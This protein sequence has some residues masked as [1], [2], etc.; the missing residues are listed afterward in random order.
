MQAL[1]RLKLPHSLRAKM[2]LWVFV[3]VV[4]IL[5]ILYATIW[6]AA[7]SF[8]TQTRGNISQLLTPFSADIDA[9]LASAKLYVANLRVDLSLLSESAQ[10]SPEG[11]QALS[12]LAENI[13]EDLALYPQIDAFFLY[14]D[15]KMRFV[16]N[17][18]RS[19]PQ[20]RA[21]ALALQDS[22]DSLGTDT[23][24]FQQGY[25]YFEVDDS[26]YLYIATN[27]RDGVVGCWFSVDSLF[28]NI[29]NADLL[30]LTRIMLSDRQGRFLD[31]EFDTRSSRQLA[32]LLEP[33][34]VT[35]TSLTAAP[36]KITVL[37]DEATVLAPV[38][39]MY[40]GALVAVS[41]A[42]LLFLLYV[43][44]L[45]ASLVRPLKRLASAISGIRSD[46]L[47]P[48]PICRSDGTEIE[49]VYHALNAMTGQIESLKIQM[50]EEKLVKQKT[51]MQLF[52]L[53]IRPHFLLNALNTIVSFAR[54]KDYDMVQK[55]TMY[56]ATHCQY[57]L[58]NPWYVTLE[59]ELVY[60]QNFIDMQSAQHDARYRYT[61]H[62][63]DEL[64]DNEIPI[65]GIQIFVENA[66]KHARNLDR[67]MEI[68]VDIDEE[69]FQGTH[70]LHISIK[71][72]GNGFEDQIL[73]ELNGQE[74][75]P[76]P[77]HGRPWYRY[78]QY[79]P[80]PENPIQRPRLG[81]FFQP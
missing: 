63:E 37:W 76:P 38:Q 51:Q 69:D 19:Y 27:V 67:A 55:M 52:Q 24:I 10:Q 41:I 48:I 30:G 59:E 72:N 3:F 28:K 36:F 6:N 17:Y 20:S 49:N 53:Q 42:C 32:Q 56:L 33:Y 47:Q 65:L 71:D 77:R 70:Y 25:L 58:Y 9:T 45:R 75:Y 4:P 64:L 39:Q 34:L 61:V 31:P 8:E 22:L 79:P 23:Q 14:G 50:Y 2:L 68:L 15:G 54:I 13:S 26:F 18:N 40:R 35:S 7:E 11:L 66:L 5:A 62:V 43:F 60:T 81:A 44:F 12:S 46:N 21:A 73:D 1:R 29:Q 16:Q 74:S 80:T 78:R 57:I